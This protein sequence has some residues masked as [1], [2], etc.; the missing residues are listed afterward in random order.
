MQAILW[1]LWSPGAGANMKARLT[2]Q[3][4]LKANPLVVSTVAGTNLTAV[5]ISL[6][7]LFVFG[8]VS[9][10]IV[11]YPHAEALKRPQTAWHAQI[12]CTRN[13]IRINMSFLFY[14]ICCRQ[15]KSTTLQPYGTMNARTQ[16]LTNARNARAT[17]NESLSFSTCAWNHM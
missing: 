17:E 14:F 4:R 3:I 7:I 16:L 11:S 5:K 15:L 8:H 13:R 1:N 2:I 12:Q 6:N 10:R 9:W